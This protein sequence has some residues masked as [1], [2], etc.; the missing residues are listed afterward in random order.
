VTRWSIVEEMEQSG[1]DGAEREK[2]H[3]VGEIKV[4]SRL[5]V[6]EVRL[7]HVVACAQLG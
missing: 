3:T 7:S 6:S 1:G 5:A 2:R 4:K